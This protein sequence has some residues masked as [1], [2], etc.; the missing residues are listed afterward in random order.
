[1][2]CSGELHLHRHPFVKLSAEKRHPK[3][4]FGYL[5]CFL[6]KA[7]DSSTYTGHLFQLC[8]CVCVCVVTISAHHLSVVDTAENASISQK[9]TGKK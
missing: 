4:W 9:S 6:E 5:A 2:S 3:E 8:V 1:M 7:Y